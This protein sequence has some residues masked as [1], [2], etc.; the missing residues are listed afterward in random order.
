[1]SR[2]KIVPHFGSAT[3]RSFLCA[4]VRTGAAAWAGLRFL[5]RA[6]LGATDRAAPNERITMGMIGM[7]RQAYHANLL[8]FL[9]SPDTQ[10]VAVCDVD[11]W[12]LEEGRKRVEE[13][14]AAQTRRGSYKGC[15]IARAFRNILARSDI[16]AVMISTPDHWHAIM[17]IDAARAGKDVALEKPMSLSIAQ[18][19]AISDAMVKHNR[20][21]RTDTE[22][23]FSGDFRRLCECVR[24]GRIGRVRRIRAE[25]PKE[26][27]PVPAQPT[28]PVPAD[29]DYSLW[30]GPA[31]EAPYTEKRV[32]TRNNLSARPGWMIIQDYCDG[33]IGNWGTHLLD[34]VQWGHNSELTGPVE[35]EGCGE[36]HPP[37]GLSD[38]LRE[39][40][41]IYRYADGVELEYCMSGRPAVRFEGDDGWIEAVWNKGVEAQPKAILDEPFGPNDLRLPLISEKIDF[42]RSVKRRTPTLIP[43]EVGHR[44]NTM[45]HLGLIAI[46]L[47]LKLKWDPVRERFDD[48]AANRLLDRPL[49]APWSI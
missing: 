4:T 33:I 21:F 36:F 41:V 31:P 37:G 48:D 5:P 25:V 15:M 39:F 35:V 26:A 13:Y 38:V 3:R 19:R 47:G 43:A 23:R 6:A 45:C 46:K 16:D 32:H 29:L 17:A 8:P 42:I 40:T 30:L 12:R 18:G 34:I 7:G 14:Y 10:V 28:M 1:M 27:D 24:N 2:L 9:A 11:A 22:V 49:R 20:I 44:T